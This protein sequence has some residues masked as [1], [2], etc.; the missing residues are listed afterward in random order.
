MGEHLL[1]WLSLLTIGISGISLLTGLVFIKLGKRDL[2][3]RAMLTASV[4]A[5]LFVMLYLVRTAL[6]PHRSYQGPYRELFSFILWSHTF[7]AIVNF[8]LA[9][10]TIRYAFREAFQQHRKV[11]PITA[12][13]WLYVAVTGWLIYAFI[14]W[15]Q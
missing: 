11:A 12:L 2:H 9:I 8:P 13:V 3:K 4:F 10:I 1:N 5:I 15:L 14:E 6:F 7:L